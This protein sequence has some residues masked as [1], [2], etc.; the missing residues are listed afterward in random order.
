MPGASGPSSLHGGVLKA[1]L[2]QFLAYGDPDQGCG[3]TSRGDGKV[4]HMS[5]IVISLPLETKTNF[6][7]AYLRLLLIATFYSCYVAIYRNHN[8]KVDLHAKY[9]C[10][11]NKKRY[12]VPDVG[13]GCF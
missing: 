7:V 13:F 10:H 5:V 6:T 2:Q 8:S 12:A 9:L 4:S 3:G 11:K 1:S